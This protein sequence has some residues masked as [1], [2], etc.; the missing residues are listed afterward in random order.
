SFMN[1]ASRRSRS[2]TRGGCSNSPRL[3]ARMILS[4]N[5]GNA[6]CRM[7]NALNILHSPFCILHCMSFDSPALAAY[8]RDHLPAAAIPALDRARPMELTQF[9]GGHSNLTF[10][11]RFGDTE[12][13]L[14]RP[15]D[16]PLP[17]RA[18]DM[19]RE[20]RWLA[21]LNPLFALAPAPY[22]L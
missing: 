4:K 14:R 22:L 3:I 12:L 19:V 5:T 8:L 15:P 7:N 9:P 18:H 17:P 10:L 1:A 2:C 11:V 6:K 21:A 20:Y 16:G 13:V